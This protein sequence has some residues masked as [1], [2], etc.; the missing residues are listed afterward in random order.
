MC[1]QYIL[2][3]NILL[4]KAFEKQYFN[5]ASSIYF[6]TELGKKKLFHHIL[7]TQIVSAYPKVFVDIFRQVI[8]LNVINSLKRTLLNFFFYTIPK[9]CTSSKINNIQ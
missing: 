1:I 5:P 2:E 6:V 9:N 7:P 4:S 8:G 3:N